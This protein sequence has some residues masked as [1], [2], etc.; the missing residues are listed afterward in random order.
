V[1]DEENNTNV[2]E[3]T[4]ERETVDFDLD[5][6]IKKKQQELQQ[7]KGSED[8]VRERSTRLE[9]KVSH[10][11]GTKKKHVLSSD[12]PRQHIPE[13]RDWTSEEIESLKSNYQL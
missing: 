11:K 8:L 9:S 10:R 5:E 2:L 3:T 6:E 12:I 4:E 13:T 1:N 7:Q